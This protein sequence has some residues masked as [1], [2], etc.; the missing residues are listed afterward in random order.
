VCSGND[1]LPPFRELSF[2]GV[3][4]VLINY[5]YTIRP[6]S[7]TVASSDL[8]SRFPTLFCNRCCRQCRDALCI[9]SN[10][11]QKKINKKSSENNP[12]NRVQLTTQVAAS[13][14]GVFHGSEIV[15]LQ[16]GRGPNPIPT[17]YCVPSDCI[18][19]SRYRRTTALKNK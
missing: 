1:K 5:Y 15:A 11:I 3:F 4:G 10:S 2:I 13:R 18:I 6:S 9:S 7:K 17:T 8:S 14:K 12:S 19:K 16:A